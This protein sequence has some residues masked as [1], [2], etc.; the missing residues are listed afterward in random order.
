[1]SGKDFEKLGTFFPILTVPVQTIVREYDINF[2]IVDTTVISSS[3]VQLE[4]FKQVLEENGYV[5][6]EHM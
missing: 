3:D 6:Y 1:V 2:V 5:L 4:G